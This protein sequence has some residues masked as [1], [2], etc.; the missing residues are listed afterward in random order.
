[1]DSFSKSLSH[2]VPEYRDKETA[3]E[4][5]TEAPICILLAVQLPDLFHFINHIR[6]E[7]LMSR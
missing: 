6:P 5:N 4:E 3:R 1:M 2:S 7:G